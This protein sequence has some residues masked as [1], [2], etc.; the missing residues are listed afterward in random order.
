MFKKILVFTM[1][2]MICFSCIAQK[3]LQIKYSVTNKTIP[4]VLDKY[5]SLRANSSFV[6]FT[7]SS[8]SSYIERVVNQTFKNLKTNTLWS[9]E[10]REFI[11]EEKMNLFNW[12]FFP[13]T[14]IILD[15]NCRKATCEFRGRYYIAWYTTDL[16]FRAAPWK[17]CGL[18]GVVLKL[19]VDDDYYVLN[20]IDLK[21][22]DSHEK[23]ETPFK[24]KKNMTWDEHV[25]TYK[26]SLK[27][28]KERYRS[29][30]IKLG[31][32][33]PCKLPQIQVISKENL[34]TGD[35][36][37]KNFGFSSDDL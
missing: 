26:N 19:V 9:L 7:E 24:G 8:R 22:K 29:D 15:Y 18:P 23:I 14:K 30:G 1:F 10:F 17:I 5:A 6:L 27:I 33:I 13:E 31:R 37:I 20:A 12:E 36:Q 2:I 32:T 28:I 3:E 34:S 11:I 35:E 16:P 4:T 21:V 25:N